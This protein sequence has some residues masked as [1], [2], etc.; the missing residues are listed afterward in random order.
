MLLFYK[1]SHEITHMQNERRQFFAEVADQSIW[2][3]F[4]YVSLLRSSK[5]IILT[6]DYG[7]LCKVGIGIFILGTGI[8]YTTVYTM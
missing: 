5:S 6:Y 4:L 3:L 7:Y 1:H 8:L 2:C